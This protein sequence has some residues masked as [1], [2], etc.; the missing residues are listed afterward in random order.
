MRIKRLGLSRLGIGLLSITVVGTAS[1]E[2]VLATEA[3][4]P[5][6]GATL[7]WQYE[8]EQGPSHWGTLAPTT[9]SCEKGTHQSPINIR[10]ASH[11][12][13]HDGM[14]I[15]YRAAS[16]HVGTSH[17]TVEVDFQ[18]GGTLELSGRSYSLKEFHFHEPSEHQLNG[19]I[20]PMEAHLVH[21]DESG[22]LVVLAIL[23]ELGTETAPL[24]DVWE[25][26]P[27]GK[28]EE[29][30]DLLFNPQDLLPKDLHHY[31]YDGSLTTPPCTEGV[32]WIVLKEPIHITAAHLERFVSLIGHNARP[33]QPLNEREVDEE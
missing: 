25:R 5:A 33:V 30:R 14:L 18:S 21:R 32:H 19:R 16:G 22:H 8:G 2:G 24:A 20:Y 27:S 6:Q 23:M 10:T 15:Q 11:P 29:V 4:P 17:H 13:G 1:A 12:H 7:A 26:I 31:A 3:G 28:Q 9:A